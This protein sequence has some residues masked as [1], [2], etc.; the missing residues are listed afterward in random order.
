M[1]QI[2]DDFPPDVKLFFIR[3]QQYLDT[4]L[5]FYGSSVRADYQV[6]KSDIDVAVFTDNESSTMA[7]LQVFL[8]VSRSDF[9]KVVWKVHDD[10]IVYGFKIKC[11]HVPHHVKEPLNCEIAIYNNNFKDILI[12]D[13]YPNIP[14]II[15][16]ILIV[17]KTFHYTI[18]LLPKSVYTVVKRFLFN[19]ILTDKHDSIFFVLSKNKDKDKDKDSGKNRDKNKD[20]GKNK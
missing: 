20:S 10:T 7:K 19:N 6:G 11:E 14:Y 17:L 3:L 9:E 8:R 18:P 16:L 2:R 1:N 12:K 5:Y 15:T 13:F 4:D